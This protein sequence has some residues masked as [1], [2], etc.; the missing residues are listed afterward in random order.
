M[1]VL[2]TLLQKTIRGGVGKS[3]FIMA[4]I[5][6]SVAIILLLAAIQAYMDFRQ[7]LYGNQQN[8]GAEFLVINK[9]ITNQNMA[10]KEALRFTPTE[11]EEI[12]K[13]DFLDAVEPVQSSTFKVSAQSPS[14]TLPF[15]TDLFFEAV[16]TTF[17][18][19]KADDWKWKED[20]DELPIILPND[21]FDLY[22]FAFAPSQGLPQ[23]SAE[24]FMALPIEIHISGNG[25]SKKMMGHVVGLSDRITSVLVPKNFMV[26]ANKRFGTES[27]KAPSRLVIKVKDPSNPALTEFLKKHQ[28]STN[29]EKTR[30][31]KYRSIV[32]T[33]VSAVG[34][35]GFTMLLFALLVFSLFIQLTI[36]HAKSEIELL[37]TL[38]VS[39]KQLRQFLLKLFFPI[40]IVITLLCLGIIQLLQWQ[41]S[42]YLITKNMIIGT[43]LSWF[44]VLACGIVLFVVY[45]VLYSTIRKYIKQK[46]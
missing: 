2:N 30:F 25:L 7:L 28:Y 10:Q 19:V 18:D 22:N 46:I 37:I 13:Q 24:T 11:I 6:L 9:I 44:S 16:D 14:A 27:E 34:G 15:Y 3:R 26:W 39:P 21:F 35:I 1:T 45:I 4:G 31:S 42:I 33:V 23:L 12:K 8:N 41:L 38:G 20:Q 40:H 36:E 43:Y 17:L 29:Q 32:E 5:G